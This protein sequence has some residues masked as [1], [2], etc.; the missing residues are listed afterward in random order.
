MSDD[1]DRVAGATRLA[2]PREVRPRFGPP[3]PEPRFSLER[4]YDLVYAQVP[5]VN[6][7]IWSAS[8]VVMGLGC[9]VTLFGASAGAGGAFGAVTPLIAAAGLAF[10]Y[11]EHDPSLEVALATPTSPRAILLA[12][13]ALVCGYDLLLALVASLVLEGV[14]DPAGGLEAVIAVWLGPM[15]LLSSIALAVAVRFGSVA[16]LAVAGTLWILNLTS[17]R[18]LEHVI[19]PVLDPTVATA[20]SIAVAFALFGVVVLRTPRVLRPT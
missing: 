11:G 17:G 4:I 7:S 16:S 10:L 14:G 20:L 15:L 13:L 18:A 8:A 2:L 5:V 1:L 19:V 12:R 9:A 3:T 6:R